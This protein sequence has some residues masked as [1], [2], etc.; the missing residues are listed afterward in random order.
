MHLTPEEFVDVAEGTR[1]ETSLP[2]LAACEQCRQGL[3]EFRAT[4]SS[5]APVANVPPVPEPSP[6]FWNHFQRRVSDAITAER[7]TEAG[8]LGWLRALAR[9]GLA[10]LSAAGAIALILLALSLRKPAPP[11]TRAYTDW[12]RPNAASP[13]WLRSEVFS[14]SL[15]DDPSL[16]LVAALSADVDLSDDETG[17]TSRT[18]AE[19]AVTHMSAED[20]QELKRLLNLEMGN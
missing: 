6:L 11:S 10:P 9:P 20:L 18:S 16:Q 2:H 5:V 7:A 14:D 15:D 1:A 19:H 13:A 17:L 8:V 3:A 4:M 12:M